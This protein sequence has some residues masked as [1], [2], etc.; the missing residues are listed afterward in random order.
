MISWVNIL[1]IYWRNSGKNLE[2]PLKEFALEILKKT[3]K[4]WKTFPGN[5]EAIIQ[6]VPGGTIKKYLKKNCVERC[7]ITKSWRYP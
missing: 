3:V 1:D 7:P 6:E 2:E 5:P 4:S